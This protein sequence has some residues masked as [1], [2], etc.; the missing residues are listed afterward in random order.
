MTGLKVARE[1]VGLSWVGVFIWGVVSLVQ[2]NWVSVAIAVV[3]FGVLGLVF[4]SV[5]T[6]LQRAELMAAFS[7]VDSVAMAARLGAW[8]EGL[9]LSTKAV[10][11]LEKSLK[12]DNGENMALPL[13]TVLL[14]HSLMLGANGETQDAQSALSRAHPLIR[15]TWATDPALAADPDMA[16]FP[17]I[18]SE[19]D[20][21]F[22]SS[23]SA[24]TRD[25]FR[26]L[27]LQIAQPL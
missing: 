22:S 16:A 26:R 15:K 24:P 1:I 27:A 10:N 19:L 13:A 8:P 20:R 25:L 7:L 11:I 18:A 6:R 17:R 9:E 4:M 5:H 23:G 2:L 3:V 12:R 14:L 21:G